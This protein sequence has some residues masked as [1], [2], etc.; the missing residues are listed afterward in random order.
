[1]FLNCKFKA[2]SI[3]LNAQHVNGMTHFDLA[4]KLVQMHVQLLGTTEDQQ[5]L[6][7]RSK[8]FLSL[9]FCLTTLKENP[10][11]RRSETFESISL[12]PFGFSFLT[13]SRDVQFHKVSKVLD[14]R[15][16]VLN[17]IVRETQFT[18][19]AQSE[20]ILQKRKIN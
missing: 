11:N 9:A 16:Q 19:F 17:F 4:W 10:Q 1:M 12:E 3:N 18:K 15:R 7:S 20:E 8:P 13:I 14:I 6:C 5:L 2:F